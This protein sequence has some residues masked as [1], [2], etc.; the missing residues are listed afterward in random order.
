MGQETDV[1]DVTLM[2]L[3]NGYYHLDCAEGGKKPDSCSWL[4]FHIC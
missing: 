1:R 4:T 2:A 3:Q